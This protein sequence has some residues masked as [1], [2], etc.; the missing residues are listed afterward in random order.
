ME[1]R[2]HGQAQAQSMLRTLRMLLWRW[3][4]G[5]RDLVMESSPLVDSDGESEHIQGPKQIQ[6]FPYLVG[7]LHNLAF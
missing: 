2:T 7:I 1:K 3:R 6:S 4:Q 5:G